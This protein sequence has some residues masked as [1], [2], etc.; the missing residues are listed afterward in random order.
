MRGEITLTD[1]IYDEGEHTKTVFAHFG[2][3][4]YMANVFETGLALAIVQL[5]F[6]TGVTDRIRREGHKTFDRR[7]YEA[8]FDAFME[9]QHA[10]T[11]GN[12][13]KR[14]SGCVVLPAD[15]RTLITEAKAKRDFLAHHYFRE[16]AELFARRRGRD[17]MIEELDA[18]MAAFAAA[19]TALETFLE[20]HRSSLGLTKERFEARVVE[21]LKSLRDED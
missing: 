17:Q 11:L 13:L 9:R 19:D 10:Q 14:V 1:A 8:D 4:Y 3:A 15:L 20:P 12:L 18:A 2:R 21:Y 16:R 5:E 7:R 6:L